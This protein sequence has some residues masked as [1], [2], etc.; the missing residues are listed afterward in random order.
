MAAGV[1]RQP[2]HPT[3]ECPACSRWLELDRMARDVALGPSDRLDWDSYLSFVYDFRDNLEGV[4]RRQ[5]ERKPG[6]GE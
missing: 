4:W 2:N 5:D 1:C 6:G 3:R